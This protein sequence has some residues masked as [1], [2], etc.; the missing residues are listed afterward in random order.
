MPICKRDPILLLN[1]PRIQAYNTVIYIFIFQIL[2][3]ND[4]T[5][6]NMHYINI[7]IN[8]TDHYT[9]IFT[10]RIIRLALEITF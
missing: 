1:S 10:Y 8:H 9:W 7:E 6:R 5:I 4:K 2:H 3:T